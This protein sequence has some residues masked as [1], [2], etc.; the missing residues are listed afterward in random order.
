MKLS[1]FKSWFVLTSM[2]SGMAVLSPCPALAQRSWVR[3]REEVPDIRNC[4]VCHGDD[5]KGNGPY[6]PELKAQPAD[7]TQLA[8][9]NNGAFPQGGSLESSMAARQ[10]PAM[11]P[12][13]CRSGV[14]NSAEPRKRQGETRPQRLRASASS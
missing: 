4:A 6:A 2:T 3:P 8:K 14:T 11:A 7:L 10:F 12:L 5:G 1:R 9:K 13:K